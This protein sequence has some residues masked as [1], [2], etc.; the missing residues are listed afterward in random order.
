MKAGRAYC[1]RLFIAINFEENVTDALTDVQ[2]EL[3]ACGAE[4]NYTRR[5]NLHLT[6]AFIGDYGNPDEVLDVMREVP[7][8]PVT[9]E[10]EGLQHYR[11]MYFARFKSS[12]G[13]E[14]YVRRLRRALAEH[15]I[16]FDKKKFMPHVTLIRKVSFLNGTQDDVPDDSMLGEVMANRV[17]LMLSERGKHGMIYTEL[18]GIDG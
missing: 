9:I 1:M 7:F 11:D 18:G 13:L 17:S 12:P 14:S 8:R 5:E 4:G 15:D 3:R 10:Y 6:L 16:P 2:E